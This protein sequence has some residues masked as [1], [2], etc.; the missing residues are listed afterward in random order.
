MSD[1]V[2]KISEVRR[3]VVN[4]INNVGMTISELCLKFHELLQKIYVNMLEVRSPEKGSALIALG[5]EGNVLG[6]FYWGP[7][8][9]VKW[10]R[11][12]F[13]CCFYGGSLVCDTMTAICL[14]LH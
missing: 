10:K 12:Y 1:N 9:L 4:I 7:D 8:G 2:S 5:G 3:A 13:L 11:Q 6:I 14:I